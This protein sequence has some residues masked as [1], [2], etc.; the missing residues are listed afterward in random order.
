LLPDHSEGTDSILLNHMIF[1]ASFIPQGDKLLGRVWNS[2]ADIQEL[3][4]SMCFLSGQSENPKSRSSK[5]CDFYSFL[6][7]QDLKAMRL[8]SR[9]W[10]QGCDSCQVNLQTH[11][12]ELHS[13]VYL[14]PGR[15]ESC[16]SR[17]S[18]SCYF[19][20]LLLLTSNWIAEWGL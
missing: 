4:P 13:G 16:T 15:I 2:E 1:T 12:Q 17:P 10:M 19:S 8:T 9:N 18:E 20:I 6:P 3:H 5:S 7:W 11:L 14:P